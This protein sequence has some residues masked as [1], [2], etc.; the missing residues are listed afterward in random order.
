MCLSSRSSLC[1]PRTGTRPLPSSSPLPVPTHTVESKKL[2]T[3]SSLGTKLPANSVV[4]PMIEYRTL[5]MSV[6]HL[7]RLVT[8]TSG[9]VYL[10]LSTASSGANFNEQLSESGLQPVALSL[11][12][13]PV[14]LLFPIL[15]FALVI[16]C[17][18][19]NRMSRG[20]FSGFCATTS[21]ICPSLLYK[22]RSASQRIKCTRDVSQVYP[23][24]SSSKRR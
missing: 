17:Q 21:S 11:C 7:V 24:S 4:P 5:R 6:F 15:A 9:T 18:I 8:E 2:T 16:V 3:H 10:R 20:H 23:A 1:P 22:R 19:S 13:F 14:R 12:S